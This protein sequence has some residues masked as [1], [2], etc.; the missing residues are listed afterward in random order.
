MRALGWLFPWDVQTERDGRLNAGEWVAMVDRWC[1]MTQ[2][3]AMR[4]AFFELA[5]IGKGPGE[6]PRIVVSSLKSRFFEFEEAARNPNNINRPLYQE[7]MRYSNHAKR[8]AH[9]S[10]NKHG[11]RHIDGIP[12]FVWFRV[13]RRAWCSHVG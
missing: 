11:L 6:F 10:R 3:E 9:S 13:R 12:T 1:T 2:K 5:S 4:F 8:E 7:L